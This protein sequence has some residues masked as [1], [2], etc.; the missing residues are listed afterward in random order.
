MSPGAFMRR[1]DNHVSPP[2]QVDLVDL[3]VYNDNLDASYL[4]T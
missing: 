4:Y 3:D 2:Q 1:V